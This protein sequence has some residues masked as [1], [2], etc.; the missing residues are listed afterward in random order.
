[1]LLYVFDR[2][3]AWFVSWRK[4]ECLLFCYLC[5]C[6]CVFKQGLGACHISYFPGATAL[7]LFNGSGKTPFHFM[8][9]RLVIDI[10]CFWGF[11]TFLSRLFRLIELIVL[12]LAC[13]FLLNIDFAH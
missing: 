11:S 3:R 6:V 7:A 5:V 12:A 13:C 1:M 9:I 4:K 2:L 10:S 8:C